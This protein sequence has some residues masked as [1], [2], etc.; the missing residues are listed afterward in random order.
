MASGSEGTYP[1][2]VGAL[3]D[4]V[5]V[6]SESGGEEEGDEE[7]EDELVHLLIGVN[8]YCCFIEL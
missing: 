5:E 7:G 6:V 4:E 3:V 1:D 2:G 8:F